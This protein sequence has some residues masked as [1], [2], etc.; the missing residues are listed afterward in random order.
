MPTQR[1]LLVAAVAAEFSK[2]SLYAIKSSITGL[3]SVCG[4]AKLVGA[5][6]APVSLLTFNRELFDVAIIGAGAADEI[7]RGEFHTAKIV[8][9][10]TAWTNSALHAVAGDQGSADGPDDSVVWRNDDPFA[11]DL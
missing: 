3:R 4:L 11:E 1:R 2:L 5:L 10:E 8:A 7:A 6:V 9:A